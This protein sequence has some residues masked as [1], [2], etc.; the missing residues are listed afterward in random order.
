[1][2]HGELEIDALRGGLDLSQRW[3]VHIGR[4]IVVISVIGRGMV[5]RLG[6]PPV[7]H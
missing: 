3:L 4:G 1:M 7:E 2:E 5:L 6:D